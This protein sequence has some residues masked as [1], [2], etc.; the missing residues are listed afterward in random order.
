MPNE[1][2]PSDQT[3]EPFHYYATCAVAWATGDSPAD[4]IRKLARLVDPVHIRR[5]LSSGAFYV[6]TCRV[7]LPASAPYGISFYMPNKTP[8]GKKV[9]TSE[10]TSWAL[11]TTKGTA[12]Q[13]D[14]NCIVVNKQV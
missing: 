13:L 3:P 5:S 2:T 10:P 9:P 14:R 6:W 4:A 7:G 11:L 8:D 12:I 1:S